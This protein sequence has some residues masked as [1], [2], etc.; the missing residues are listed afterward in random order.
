MLWTTEVLSRIQFAFTITF[1][2]VFPTLNVGL[3][4]FL[5]YWESLYLKTGAPFYK[6]L[7]Q[8]WSKI[9]ALSFGMGVVS[10]VVLAYELGANFSG[11]TYFAGNILGP[12]M[13]METLSAFFLEAGF[14][15]I[16]LFGW[17]KVTARTHFLSTC[18]VCAGTIIS[19]MWIMSANSFMHTPAGYLIEDGVLVP[20]S[21]LSAIFNPSYIVRS[22]HMLVASLLSTCFVIMGISSYYLIKRQSVTYASASF[23]PALF[24]AVVLS[25]TQVG[26]GDLVGINVLENQPIKTAAMEGNWQTQAGAPLILFAIPDQKNQRNLYE[27]KIPKLASLINTH[28]WDGVLPGL[29]QAPLDRQPPVASVFFTFRIMVGIGF[30][31]VLLSSLGAYFVYKKNLPRKR[32]YLRLLVASMPL[33]FVATIC[34][35]MTS[36]IGRQPWTVYNLLLT[37]DSVSRLPAEQVMVSLLTIF[38]VYMSFFAAYLYFM[39][40]TV[41]K[42][43]G[44]LSPPDGLGYLISSVSKYD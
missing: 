35:W 40:K 22:S 25:I 2:G 7:C 14:L 29:D 32:W 39:C 4:V 13:T 19:L 21:W 33:G 44:D 5:V 12:L 34:G 27:I 1:H 8:F 36:E 10:G 3:G 11:F 43:P 18:F 41:R 20:D 26:L 17:E 30:L 24:V 16:M 9:F 31:F 23:I 42:G 38:V 6:S 28:S 37:K 15:G